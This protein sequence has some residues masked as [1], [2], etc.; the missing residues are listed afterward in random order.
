M[1]TYT[2]KLP[3]GTTSPYMRRGQE[4]PL[5]DVFKYLVGVRLD[6]TAM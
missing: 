3:P 2:L 6:Y 4:K 5:Y 1:D